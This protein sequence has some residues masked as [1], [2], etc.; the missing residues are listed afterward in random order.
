LAALF[1]IGSVPAI[2]AADTITVE[3]VVYENVYLGEGASNY[4]IQVPATGAMITVPKS[5]VNERD[6]QITP[7]RAERRR[8]RDQWRAKRLNRAD[9]TPATGRFESWREEL[10]ATVPSG[11]TPDAIVEKPDPAAAGGTPPRTAPTAKAPSRPPALIPGQRAGD[12]ATPTPPVRL[13]NIE[14]FGARFSGQKMFMDQNGVAVITNRPDQFEGRPEYVEVTIHYDPIEVPSEFRLASAKTNDRGLLGG[15]SIDDM[16]AYYARRHMLDPA[17][18]YAVIKVESGGN[19]YAVS[20]AGARGLMQLMPGTAREMGVKDI[21]DPAE[22]IAGGTQYLSKMFALF[23]E[24]IDLA[25]AGYN[26]GPGNVKK[27]GGVPPFKETQNYIK[28]VRRYQRDFER[29]GS[30]RID[31]GGYKPVDIAYLPPESSRFYQIVLDNGLTV[32][33]DHIYPDGDRYIYWFK[34]RSGHF[35]VENVISVR[36]PT[37]S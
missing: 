21:F 30:P 34:G 19:R 13:S 32:A 17:L 37:T 1:V 24:D 25:L 35:P 36:E 26:A 15:N 10:S 31:L 23:N 3:G 5:A 20:S 7:D 14:N 11:E 6:I 28:L 8:L 18:V 22:N 27:Y 16:I 9:D 4:Y 12:V 2:A 33:A 29:S